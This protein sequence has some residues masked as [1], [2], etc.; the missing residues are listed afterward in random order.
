MREPWGCKTSAAEPANLTVRMLLR[1]FSR[2]TNGFSRKLTTAA[3]EVPMAITTK[4]KL[5]TSFWTAD[6]EVLETAIGRFKTDSLLA[7]DCQIVFF[8]I[9][10]D[11]H[12]HVNV[13]HR[14]AT[15]T[16]SGWAGPASLPDGFVH[17]RTF[18][19]VQASQMIRHIRDMV[20]AP[21]ISK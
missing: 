15:M 10:G 2:L 6:V 14:H 18:G 17:N 8:E 12:L 19:D 1:P 9:A 16:V 21:R 11:G 7:N 4:R 20:F 13:I 5:L 3:V